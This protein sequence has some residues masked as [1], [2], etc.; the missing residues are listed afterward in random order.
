MRYSVLVMVV[1]FLIGCGGGNTSNPT[2]DGDTNKTEENSITIKVTPH[3]IKFGYLLDDNITDV[4]YSIV[5]DAK[6]GNLTIIDAKSGKY[7][8]LSS[9]N[10]NDSFIYQI[11]NDN[12]ITSNIE[13]KILNTNLAIMTNSGSIEDFNTSNP[14]MLDKEL[15][16]FSSNLPI[17]VIDIGDKQIPDEP[18]IM[19]SIALFEPANDSNR[20]SIT[21]TPTYS[22]YIEIE[23]RGGSSQ[24]Y[25]PKK[26]YGVD[27]ILSDGED[28]DVSLLGMPKE[29][30]WIL[31]APYA[32]K[33]LM[34]NYLAYHKTRDINDSKYYAVRSEFVEVLVRVG[35]QYRYDGLYVFME[36]IKR[37]K[38]RLDIEK[39]KEEDN[40]PP[41][42]TG[43]Y[44]LKK[45]GEP[46]DDEYEVL[47]ALGSSFIVNY[48]DKDKLTADQEY[49]IEN[50][51]QSVD[52]AIESS[53]FNDTN[54]PNYYGNWIDV[55]SFVVHI[56]SREFFLDVDTWIFS[57]YLYKDRNK[58]LAMTPVWDFN[59]GMGNQDF[60]LDGRYDI[61]AFEYLRTDEGLENSALRRWIEKLMSDPSFKAKVASKWSDLRAGIWSDA[62]LSS[63]IST[64]KSNIDEAANRNFQR[65]PNVLGHNIWGNRKA[66]SGE[67][68]SSYDD[69][70]NV[71]MK[72]W[73]LNRAGWIDSQL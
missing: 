58:T 38:D 26:Q 55:D 66:C 18:K 51:I 48:P 59:L 36:K 3:I 1:F 16:N 62:Q 53:D 63:F 54:S 24:Y 19:G 6:E 2:V 5:E 7:S 21:D 45:D 34:R 11:K 43:G 25:Y 28:D 35:D 70:V 37:D 65:W 47:T 50:H 71:G 17:I 39:L 41:E 22:G 29:H 4:I 42:I 23:R 73:L 44:I 64:T 27:T 33:S 69:A 10:S 68:C 14:E 52:A 8:Y 31:Q 57:E 32:D 12:N 40:L 30:K 49:Y 13:V 72:E 9:S 20:T 60:R 67:Y 61:W 15:T 56:L 46:D